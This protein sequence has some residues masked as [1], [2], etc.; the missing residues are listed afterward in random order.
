M[1]DER[2]AKTYCDKIFQ[3]LIVQLLG[4]QGMTTTWNAPVGETVS[5]L[6]ATTGIVIMIAAEIRMQVCEYSLD[7]HENTIMY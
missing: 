4:Q 3:H 2:R 5:S 6:K 1:A 7:Q